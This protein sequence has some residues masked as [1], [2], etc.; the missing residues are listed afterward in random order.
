MSQRL[1][2]E[3]L[4]ATLHAAFASAGMADPGAYTAPGGEAIPCS[5]YVDRDGQPRG[6]FG[7]VRSPINEVAYVLGSM[8]IAPVQNGTLQVDGQILV[9]AKEISNDGSLSRWMVRNG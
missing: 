1:F 2:L 4:D 6:E 8:P 7:Q 5:V 3:G 9:N